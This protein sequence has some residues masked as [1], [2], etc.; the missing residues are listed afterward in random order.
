MPPPAATRPPALKA[1][2]PFLCHSYPDPRTP[3]SIPNALSW[4]HPCP[5]PTVPGPLTMQ[6]PQI[7]LLHPKPTATTL[8]LPP[9]RDHL[10]PQQW[11]LAVGVP[12][13]CSPQDLI[14]VMVQLPPTSPS[15]ILEVSTT[16]RVLYGTW[17]LRSGLSMRSWGHTNGYLHH[18]H[19]P[20][21]AARCNSCSAAQERAPTAWGKLHALH[22]GGTLVMASSDRTGQG[23]RGLGS[24]KSP[25]PLQGVFP[26]CPR[27]CG[28]DARCGSHQKVTPRWCCPRLGGC[29]ELD[30]NG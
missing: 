18:S 30:L 29:L 21:R 3:W 12:T 14:Q 15:A 11:D 2:L 20:A 22:C 7:A 28:G 5:L 27:R 4:Y 24:A 1:P 10:G 8:L 19:V 6:E 16:L 9:C 25:R 17:G 13:L 23:L 26:A